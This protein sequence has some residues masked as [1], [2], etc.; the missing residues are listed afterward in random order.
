VSLEKP[1][2]EFNLGDAVEVVVNPV[3]LTYHKGCVRQI[4][5]HFK[6]RMWFYWLEESEK[7]VSKRYAASDLRAVASGAGHP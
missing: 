5:W 4:V 7:K 2:P 1:P 3:N 6:H